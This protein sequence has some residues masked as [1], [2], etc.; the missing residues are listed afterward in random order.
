VLAVT[1][2]TLSG[3]VDRAVALVRPPGHHAEPDTAMGFCIYNNVA[4]AAWAA[5]RKLGA[6]RVLIVDW[7]VHHGALRRLAPRIGGVLRAPLHQGPRADLNQGPHPAM[8][9]PCALSPTP[10]PAPT[11]TRAPRAHPARR[12][13][14]AAH[15]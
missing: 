12:Q 4:V 10:A 3:A 13:R 7:D 6:Q 15:V 14:H 11:S 1:E 9:V 2:S 8:R 5:T